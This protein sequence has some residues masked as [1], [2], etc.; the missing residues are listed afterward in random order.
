LKYL[1]EQYVL[2][3]VVKKQLFPRVYIAQRKNAYADHGVAK[4]HTWQAVLSKFRMID[5]SGFGAHDL[6][7][8]FL[9]WG[10]I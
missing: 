3:T 9:V 10:A 7:V 1:F 2:W 6:T 8:K 4:N 5:K